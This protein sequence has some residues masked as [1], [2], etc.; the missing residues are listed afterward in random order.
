MT[1][2]LNDSAAQGAGTTNGSALNGSTINGSPGGFR[3]QVDN[4]LN[5]TTNGATNGATKPN[6][7]TALG[8]NNP[9]LT[10]QN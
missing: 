7:N 1:N 4:A 5:T 3:N 6:S 2:Q 10:G 9:V 8:A